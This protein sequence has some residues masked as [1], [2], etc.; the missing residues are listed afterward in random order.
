MPWHLSAGRARGELPTLPDARVCSYMYGSTPGT[1]GTVR[2][3]DK[4]WIFPV[5]NHN[6][7]EP[8]VTETVTGRRS[9]LQSPR[10]R[11]GGVTKTMHGAAAVVVSPA[12]ECT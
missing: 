3:L 8:T 10:T 7:G 5:H 6:N 9:R 12:C 4:A 1:P 2:P 11:V